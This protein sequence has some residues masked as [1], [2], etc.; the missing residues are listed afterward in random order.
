M[1]RHLGMFLANPL[2]VPVELLDY[3]AEQMGIDDP[4]CVKQYTEREKTKLE[5][6]WEI[7]Q[8][9]GLRSFAAVE[10][11]PSAWIAD[12]A[13][14]T[15]DGPKAILEGAIAW[16]RDRQALLPGITTLEQLVAE[17]RQ[18]A[19]RRLRRTLA[20][21]VIPEV[22]GALLALLDVPEGKDKRRRV[23]ELERLRRGVFRSSSKGMVA[24]LR[25]LGDIVF[26]LLHLLGRQ[27]RPQLANLPDQRLWHIAPATDYG[28]LD[29]A[30]R[31][32]HRPRP[33]YPALGGHVPD[34]GVD[35]LR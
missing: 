14:V 3:L 33:D 26:G 5:H 8:E 25:R 4:S 24:A 10:S 6:A 27:Y 34:R 31:G 7:Q 13:W 30:A 12:Q 28:P 23:S 15:G 1:V 35:P 9:Y 11:E 17:G 32:P 19:D 18:A 2:D 21:Q 29:R 16:L 22:A 20:D